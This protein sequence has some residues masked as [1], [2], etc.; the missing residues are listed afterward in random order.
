[1]VET[2]VEFKQLDTTDVD[3]WIGVPVGGAQPKLPFDAN[4]IRRF[5]Q[6]MDNPH[7]LYWDDDYAARSPFGGIVAPQS[8][9][10]GGPGTGATPAIQGTIP[11]SH[12][13]FGGDE[14]WFYG[15][16][17]YPGDRLRLDRM[18]FDYRVTETRFAGPT[19]FSR[20]DTTYVTQRGD[21]VAKQRSTAI[22]YLVENAQKLQSLMSDTEE[23]EWSDE[24]LES[25]RREKLDWVRSFPGATKRL[26]GDVAVGEKMTRRPIGP[27]SLQTFTSESRTEQGPN[28]W[29]AYEQWPPFTSSTMSSGWLPEMA[30]EREKAAIDPSFAD[31]L[32][33]GPS[34]G[35][36]QPRYAN[37]IG[38]PRGYGYG[39]TMCCW[40]VDYL[41]NWAGDWGFLRHHKTQYRNPA[42]TGNVTYLTGEVTNKWI[43]EEFGHA[44]AE[45]TY[46]MVT[47][48][49]TQMAR[50]VA[51]IELPQSE[52]DDSTVT[53]DV[54]V[55]ERLAKG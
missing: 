48:G 13:L 2:A 51:E 26:W 31:G 28:A 17:V 47:H 11:G 4:D 10:G 5:V 32:V 9:F 15:P 35:H 7:R 27:H 8:Y 6:G 36:A 19:M 24:E 49:G 38:M 53:Q 14:Q 41:A 55:R 42:L 22:R 43:D 46:E 23:P 33:Y 34:R 45:L 44:V 21:F 40:V 52:D 54:R 50:G 1:M 18:L 3:R 20:G 25:I 29:G 12:M 37:V 39:A 16:R 30:G